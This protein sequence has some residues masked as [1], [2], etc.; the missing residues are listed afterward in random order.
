ME[1]T[2]ATKKPYSFLQ[3]DGE[4]GQ[5]IRQYNWAGTSIGRPEYW[6]QSLRTWFS[7]LLNTRFP[8]LIWWGSGPSRQWRMAHDFIYCCQ[9]NSA[10]I[11]FKFH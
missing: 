1:I 5:L 7:I 11:D 4:M 2:L 9:F 8:M 3:G 6:P 10:F